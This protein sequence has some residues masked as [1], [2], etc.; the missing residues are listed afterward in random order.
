M[1]LTCYIQP[2]LTD[3]DMDTTAQETEDREQRHMAD[4]EHIFKREGICTPQAAI[5][6][7]AVYQAHAFLLCLQFLNYIVHTSS[8]G[9]DWREE[10]KGCRTKDEE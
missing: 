10:G 7:L 5:K 9:L 3:Y 4:I 1:K 6:H 2:R 8:E